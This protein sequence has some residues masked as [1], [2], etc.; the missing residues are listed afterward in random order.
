MEENVQNILSTPRIF[1]FTPPRSFTI[2]NCYSLCTV[3]VN[4]AGVTVRPDIHYTDHSIYP[5]LNC[6]S[7]EEIL[8]MR[9]CT[10]II[11]TGFAA[12]FL[13][14][15]LVLNPSPSAAADAAKGQI[16][17]IA[18]D[19][20]TGRTNIFLTD[21]AGNTTVNLTESLHVGNI[22]GFSW[23]SDG[24]YLAFSDNNN[25]VYRMELSTKELEIVAEDGYDPAWSPLGDTIVYTSTVDGNREIYTI[26]GVNLTRSGGEEF[27]PVW[28]RD[29]K[30]IFY[31]DWE[32]AGNYYL[33][34]MESNGQNVH[35]YET[36][37]GLPAANQVCMRLDGYTSEVFSMSWSPDYKKCVFSRDT[38]L[39][40]G[41]KRGEIVIQ[42]IETEM[43]TR[44]FEAEGVN[45]HPLWSPDGA[46]IVF[47]S[48][49]DSYTEDGG[50][51]TVMNLYVM[52]TDGSGQ[53]RITNLGSQGRIIKAAWRP[54][55]EETAVSESTGE[56]PAAVSLGPVF[57]NPFN[58]STTIT[59]TL[60]SSGNA[61]LTVYST[62][63][64]MV[65]ELANG[66]FSAGEYRMVWDGRDGN[67]R[68]VSSGVYFTRLES[69]GKAATA[70][71][72]L[73]R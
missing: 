59:F 46:R 27:Q 70:K 69:I 2:L 60:P 37:D 1:P 21:S 13:V 36:T 42:D 5:G 25:I 4:R 28:T 12:I 10:R 72:T 45:T 52:N 26:G 11:F 39:W 38:S 47:L 43:E 66:N 7:Q 53:T 49:R 19:G 16:T 44:L 62:T 18:R 33:Y 54:L 40:G 9:T 65:R 23:S 51:V 32:G 15:A 35:N 3:Q 67:G 68:A 58:P 34:F 41:P 17:Y 61:R 20:V 73:L 6:L 29:G 22:N 56:R 8:L 55:T 57:P 14:A 71:V 24:E 31:S 63:G 64:Q 48:N 50:T 30:I